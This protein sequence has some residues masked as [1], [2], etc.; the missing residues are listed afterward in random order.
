[1]SG[2]SR[3]GKLP[4]VQDEP[5]LY[6]DDEPILSSAEKASAT[7]IVALHRAAEGTISDSTMSIVTE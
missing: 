7:R 4:L 2:C 1:M 3:L 6:F 5:E